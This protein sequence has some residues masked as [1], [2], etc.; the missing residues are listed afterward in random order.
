MAAGAAQGEG[1]AQKGQ[2]LAEQRCA[3]CHVIGVQNPHGGVSN[4]PSFYIFAEKPD[5]YMER[6]QSFYER[7]PHKGR[8]MEASAQ[9][10]EHIMTYVRTLKRPKK[11][12]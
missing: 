7:R 3:Q 11:Q 2:V 5:V 12:P 8:D 10:L 9:D 1:D 4:S 6:L